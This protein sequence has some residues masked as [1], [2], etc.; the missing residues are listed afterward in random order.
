M[1]NYTV[2]TI[3]WQDNGV[4]V[5]TLKCRNQTYTI[6]TK[7]YRIGD[8]DCLTGGIQGRIELKVNNTWG[9][10]CDDLVNK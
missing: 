6:E 4:P 9:T 1:S 10:V 7:D 5:K 3:P 2:I 8:A